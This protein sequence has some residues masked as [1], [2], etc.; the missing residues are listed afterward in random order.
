MIELC[1][2]RKPSYSYVV[3]SMLYSAITTFEVFGKTTKKGNQTSSVVVDATKSPFYEIGVAETK[4]H[5]QLREGEKII[6][7][8]SIVNMM[9]HV[10]IKITVT[11]YED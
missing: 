2:N 5:N 8:R 4:N 11:D 10:Q 7:L 1:S 9:I 6:L 3:R